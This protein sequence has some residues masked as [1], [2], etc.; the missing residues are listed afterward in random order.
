MGA[1]SAQKAT[2][3]QSDEEGLDLGFGLSK[4]EKEG[5]GAAPD[6]ANKS[7]ADEFDA[8]GKEM[9]GMSDDDGPM[10]DEHQKAIDE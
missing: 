6:T 8:Y 10:T 1:T 5:L 3:A 4:K 2:G 7:G 9:E